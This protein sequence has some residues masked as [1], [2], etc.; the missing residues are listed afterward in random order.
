MVRKTILFAFVATLFAMPIF[1]QEANG[2]AAPDQQFYTEINF[3]RLISSKDWSADSDSDKLVGARFGISRGNHSFNLLG[4]GHGKNLKNSLLF[5][6]LPQYRYKMDG[7]VFGFGLTSSTDKR[8]RSIYSGQIKDMV[9]NKL[10]GRFSESFISNEFP[11][12]LNITY[13][14]AYGIMG[15]ELPKGFFLNAEFGVD[16]GATI[17][18]PDHIGYEIP[19]SLRER[20]LDADASAPIPLKH[21]DKIHARFITGWR[22]KLSAD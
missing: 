21:L 14:T 2:S 18:N 17:F 9:E 5:I 16:F 19:E 11:K 4:V 22:Y 3:S 12:K 8:G 7:G 20:G 10:R 1:A 15:G 6:V 13:W